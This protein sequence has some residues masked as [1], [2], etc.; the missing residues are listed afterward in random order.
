MVVGFQNIT[1]LPAGRR[2]AIY[3]FMG[4]G[5]TPEKRE[6]TC[7]YEG[8]MKKYEKNRRNYEG[9][10]NEYDP[11]SDEF[12]GVLKCTCHYVISE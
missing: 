7:Q 2:S 11:K 12:N 3:E 10:M 5:G 8:N 6:E 1:S 9:R 4:L